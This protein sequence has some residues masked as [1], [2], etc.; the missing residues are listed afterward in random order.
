MFRRIVRLLSNNN[1]SEYP[2]AGCDEDQ[3]LTPSSRPRPQ[4]KERQGT[5]SGVPKKKAD[6]GLPLPLL[7]QLYPEISKQVLIPAG[8]KSGATFTPGSRPAAGFE[9]EPFCGR[10]PAGEMLSLSEELPQY[11]WM[12][13]TTQGSV[14]CATGR[15]LGAPFKP[16]LLRLE[17]ETA[18]LNSQL[19]QRELPRLHPAP[20][21][22]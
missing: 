3:P 1:V 19:N 13:S 21:E 11:L 14:P 2:F 17:W 9:H 20:A 7:S 16:P 4:G 15:T 6:M 10:Q 8:E 18:K 22:P 12:S 5:T